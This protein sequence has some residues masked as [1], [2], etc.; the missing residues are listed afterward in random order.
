MTKARKT[1]ENNETQEA[2][3]ANSAPA[4]QE[5]NLVTMIKDG[6][7]LEVHASCVTAHTDK[8]WKLC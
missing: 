5:E 6:M 2:Q 7:K 4:V 8:G 3:G 1:E